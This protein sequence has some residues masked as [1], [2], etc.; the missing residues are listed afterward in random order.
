MYRARD[1]AL[2]RDVAI[3]VLLTA[4]ADDPDRLARFTREARFLPRSTIPTSRTSMV[5]QTPTACARL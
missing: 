4:V 5:S 3:K 1:T 2:N